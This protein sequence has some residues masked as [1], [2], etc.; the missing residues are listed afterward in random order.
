MV[1]EC[2]D[3]GVEKLHA[4]AIAQLSWLYI[5]TL[6]CMCLSSPFANCTEI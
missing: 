1:V 5:A 2:M 3:F 6:T 4:I